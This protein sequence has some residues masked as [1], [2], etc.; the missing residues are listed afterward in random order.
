MVQQATITIIWFFVGI[1]LLVIEIMTPTFFISCFGIGCI[2]AALT[3]AIFG[4][5]HL[6]QLVSFLIATIA[7]FILIKPLSRHVHP[8]EP[9]VK[10]GLESMPGKMATVLEQ[11]GPGTAPGRVK[12][13]SENWKACALDGN[14]L[15]IGEP[16]IIERIE[17][18]TL[19]VKP[20]N[21]DKG[22][23]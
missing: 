7:A 2:A 12:I 13:G 10:H 16:V 17:G 23:D 4:Q 18:V 20:L 6:M 1:F 8:R 15:F 19:F 21:Q 14:I 3:G 22:R 11:I 5:H 9:K